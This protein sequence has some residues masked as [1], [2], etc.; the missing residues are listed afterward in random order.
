M[1]PIS[2]R[3]ILAWSPAIGAGLIVA[4]GGRASAAGEIPS[5]HSRRSSEVGVVRAS[6]GRTCDLW[7]R[8]KRDDGVPLHGF[9]AGYSVQV[10]EEVVLS[11]RRLGIVEAMPLVAVVGDARV[12]PGAVSVVGG[13]PVETLGAFKT[14]AEAFGP[15]RAWL[16]SNVRSGRQH[17]V[18]YTTG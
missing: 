11:D 8:G 4:A 10:G 16:S 7:I 18:A 14:S 9:P 3:R 13:R 5:G 12:E 2:R 15:R 6:D 1:N 17:V